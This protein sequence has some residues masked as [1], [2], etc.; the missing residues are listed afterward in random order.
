M[1]ERK[2]LNCPIYVLFLISNVFS[3]LFFFLDEGD[4]KFTVKDFTCERISGKGD[5]FLSHIF[6]VIIP[7]TNK[8]K[9]T[10]LS[11]I[12]KLSVSSSFHRKMNEELFLFEKEVEFY[13]KIVPA[14]IKY[15][16][17]DGPKVLPP[18]PKC[19]YGE[20][21][22]SNGVL[23]L[24][25]LYDAGYE[26]IEITDGIDF[27]EALETMKSF[28]IFHALGYNLNKE[29]A[30]NMATKFPAIFK[31]N[32]TSVT[33]FYEKCVDKILEI[34]NAIPGQEEKRVDVSKACGKVLKLCQFSWQL[35]TPMLTLCNGDPWIGNV[36]FR[37]SRNSSG[38]KKL[39]KAILL[40]FQLNYYA[41]SMNDVSEIIA[42]SCKSEVQKNKIS[43]L[44]NMY[45]KTLLETLKKLNISLDYNYEQL[46]SD[47]KKCY[48]QGFIKTMSMIVM[49][50]LVTKEQIAE[51]MG[52]MKETEE[53]RD[54]KYKELSNGFTIKN[55]ELENRLL[56]VISDAIKFDIF[57]E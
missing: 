19:Y 52:N 53:E 15:Q 34:L 33:G 25:N 12:I 38:E 55:K 49:F 44:L 22:G 13:T 48:F 35:N 50:G 10:C 1:K 46:F 43:E 16:T 32:F 27:P 28:A 14:M 47:Y 57:P 51:F 7:I 56:Q 2:R 9:E 39:H 21:D 54:K 23:V 40:D 5:G 36:L 24:E 29:V 30:E 31:K 45:L 42:S 26:R 4:D 37:Y 18:V 20:F 6:K 11:L 41:A 17:Q 8:G 3:N